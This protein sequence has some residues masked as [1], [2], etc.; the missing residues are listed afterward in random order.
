MSEE[1]SEWGPLWDNFNKALDNWK[2][3]FES[4]QKANIQ[5]QEEYNKV[6]EKATQEGSVDT[7]RQFGENWLKCLT[8]AGFVAFKEFNEQWNKAMNDYG[9]KSFQ[10]F[11]QS[12][13]KMMINDTGLQ[14][15][16][17]YGDMMK[18][19]AETWNV[20]WPQK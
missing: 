10:D 2:Q 18:K 5:M 8:D 6:M 13:Q 9:A 11:G 15:M 14:Q 12:W 16:K 17:S 4:M 1:K 19:F 20:M 3:I 7:M